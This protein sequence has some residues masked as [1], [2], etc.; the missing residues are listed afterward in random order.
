MGVII[1]YNELTSYPVGSNNPK[2]LHAIKTRIILLGL[3]HIN[4]YIYLLCCD[5]SNVV[6]KF[7][8]FVVYGIIRL[9]HK[10]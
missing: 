8:S 3:A 10:K 6:D 7:N 9:L 4:F 5:S 2:L 1:T